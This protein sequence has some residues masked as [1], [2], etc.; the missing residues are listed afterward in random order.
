M[1][2]KI[3]LITFFFHAADNEISYLNIE[4]PRFDKRFRDFQ[5]SDNA[6]L[7]IENIRGKFR[8]AAFLDGFQ[9]NVTYG[10]SL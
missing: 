8:A 5:G 2:A 7:K 9:R 10:L 6:L 1:F 3:Y 4:L